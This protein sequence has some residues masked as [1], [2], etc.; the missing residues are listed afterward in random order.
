MLST[1]PLLQDSLVLATVSSTPSS[2]T[3]YLS[4][5]STNSCP[6]NNIISED[7][8]EVTNYNIETN[9]NFDV[10][11]EPKIEAFKNKQKTNTNSIKQVENKLPKIDFDN[12]EEAFIDF[13]ENFRE[14]S[15]KLPKYIEVASNM[16]QNN[17]NMFHIDMKDIKNFNRNLSGFLVAQHRNLNSDITKILKTFIADLELGVLNHGLYFTM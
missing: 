4:S 17:W 16:M 12:Y 11:S 5:I 7:F 3:G 6:Q 13:L 9:N 8:I 2:S 10:L 14:T 15:E 1:A